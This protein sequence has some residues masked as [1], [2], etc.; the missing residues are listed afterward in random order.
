MSGPTSLLECLLLASEQA[1]GVPVSVV[2]VIGLPVK[3]VAVVP[4]AGDDKDWLSGMGL[5]VRPGRENRILLTA[6]CIG[7]LLDRPNQSTKEAIKLS[8][9]ETRNWMRGRDEYEQSE[10][11][12]SQKQPIQEFMDLKG[13]WDRQLSKKPTPQYN[14]KRGPLHKRSAEP[15]KSSQRNGSLAGLLPPKKGQKERRKVC[16]ALFNSI[17][18]GRDIWSM[19]E[20]FASVSFLK[21]SRKVNQVAHRVAHQQRCGVLPPD[22]LFRRRLAALSTWKIKERK[23]TLPLRTIGRFTTLQGIL[24]NLSRLVHSLV[25]F[26]ILVVESGSW[27]KVYNQT[28]LA[29][30]T[31]L[32]IRMEKLTWYNDTLH[33]LVFNPPFYTCLAPFHSFR[34]S[35]F[36]ASVEA[37]AYESTVS[38]EEDA[39]AKKEKDVQRRYEFHLTYL[40]LAYYLLGYSQRKAKIAN[41]SSAHIGPALFNYQHCKARENR[42]TRREEQR[43]IRTV[44]DVTSIYS[45]VLSSEAR[46]AKNELALSSPVSR[47]ESQKVIADWQY[48]YQKAADA[49][50]LPAR[51]NIPLRVSSFLWSNIKTLQQMLFNPVWVWKPLAAAIHQLPGNLSSI[52]GRGQRRRPLLRSPERGV[53]LEGVTKKSFIIKEFKLSDAIVNSYFKDIKFVTLVCLLIGFSTWWILVTEQLLE[54]PGVLCSPD[55][56]RLMK[57]TLIDQVCSEHHVSSPCN[58]G[59]P[60]NN[61]IRED[62]YKQEFYDPLNFAPNFPKR[63]LARFGTRT[64]GDYSGIDEDGP[65]LAEMRRGAKAARLI[66]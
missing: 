32:E 64:K 58:C 7:Y 5:G 21:V 54:G 30:T 48:E 42:S 50:L 24:T 29:P 60:I 39:T 25:A 34:N 61:Q 18:F 11:Q 10:E 16:F 35:D 45:P 59:E 65:S 19:C 43:M 57:Y 4:P 51:I 1:Y 41:S 55:I 62:F 17:P 33:S 14:Y 40:A 46:T 23:S 44:L 49:L 2:P 27:T 13:M 6:P 47:R 38:N 52:F 28:F 12:L 15:V 20:G 63:T 3:I 31:R 26:R 66:W 56:A 37:K 36:S 9:L 53:G 8:S 22:W